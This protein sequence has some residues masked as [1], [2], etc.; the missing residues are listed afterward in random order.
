MCVRACVRVLFRGRGSSLEGVRRKHL[1]SSSL[2]VALPGG[3]EPFKAW[4]LFGFDVVDW[5]QRRFPSLYM[6][7][8]F[9]V[10]A[11]PGV[12]L[13]GYMDLFHDRLIK[14]RSIHVPAAGQKKLLIFRFSST[15]TALARANFSSASAESKRPAKETD[16]CQ[17]K[18]QREVP[19]LHRRLLNRLSAVRR[20][21]ESR[22]REE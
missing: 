16:Q 18:E 10:S 13:Q 11:V 14:P 20:R 1:E 7:S 5:P 21:K 2:F 3:A 12:I 9:L 15:F 4:H 19:P 6:L 22:V 8:R 17:S